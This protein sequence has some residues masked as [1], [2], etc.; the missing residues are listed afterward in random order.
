MHVHGEFA[1]GTWAD[2]GAGAR[3]V[4]EHRGGDIFST[5]QARVLAGGEP[6]NR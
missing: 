2:C 1:E 3:G 4:S 5:V 6:C